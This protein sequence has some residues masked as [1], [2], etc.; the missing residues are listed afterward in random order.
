MFGLKGAD[1]VIVGLLAGS[2]VSDTDTLPDR[3][4]SLAKSAE[5]C[6]RLNAQARDALGRAM[7]ELEQAPGQLARGAPEAGEPEGSDTLSLVDLAHRLGLKTE[8]R[9][10]DEITDEMAQMAVSA[11]GD[12]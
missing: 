9:T 10:A 2:F 12:R 6:E 7:R 4:R 5:Q 8:G 1:W 11:A 3:M